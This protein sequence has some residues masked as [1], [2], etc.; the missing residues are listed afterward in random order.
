MIFGIPPLAS[1]Y[2]TSLMVEG[3]EC[4]FSDSGICYN[5]KLISHQGKPT[6]KTECGRTDYSGRELWCALE[7]HF[8]PGTYDLVRKNC[9]AFSDAALFFL[10][11][12]RLDGK[13]STLDRLG[14]SSLEMVSRVTRGMYVPNPAADDFDVE[15]VIDAVTRASSGSKRV[16]PTHLA[17]PRTRRMKLYVG[18]E[19]NIVGLIDC[20]ELNGE[21]ATIARYN[22]L[23][24]RWEVILKATGEIKAVRAENLRPLNEQLFSIGEGVI[25]DGLESEAGMAWNGKEG[26]ILRYLEDKSRY[27]VYVAG[28]TLAL[29]AENLKP[30]LISCYTYTSRTSQVQQL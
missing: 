29:T 26:Q 11:G 20:V 30:R 22:V 14:K 7:A 25:I 1:A 6:E 16:V 23:N 13:Y 4:F 15:D 27:E 17:P 3:E 24:G 5:N 10:I 9:N 12:S 28:E 21:E 19:V 2:H 8:R 18:A